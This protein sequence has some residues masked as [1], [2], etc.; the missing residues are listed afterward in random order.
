ML[1]ELLNVKELAKIIK[2]KQGT[3]YLWVNQRK[4]PHIKLGKKVLF[5]PKDIAHW[6]DKNTVK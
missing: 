3:I 5:N 2:V 6:I 4:I 1:Q